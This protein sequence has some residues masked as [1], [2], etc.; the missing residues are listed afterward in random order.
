MHKILF[1][2]FLLSIPVSGF[3]QKETKKNV[4]SNTG[5][6]TKM[7][8]AKQKL[9]AGD[10]AGALNVYRDIEKTNPGNSTVKYY[11]GYCQFLLKQYDA[12]KASLLKAVELNSELKPET[13]VVLGQLYQ[14]EEKYDDAISQFDLFNALA[15]KSNVDEEMKDDAKLHLSQCQVAKKLIANPLKVTV[16]NL[17]AGLNS[18]YDDKN[19]CMTADGT[20]LVFT[21]RRPETTSSE[22]D[23]EGDGGYY[24]NIYTSSLDSLTK[25]FIKTESAGGTINS[26][27]H[28]ACTSIS[29]DGKQIFI[30]KNDA[31]KLE[32]RGGNVF[33]SKVAGDKWKTPATLGKPVNSKYWEG[34]A[35]VSPDGKTYFFSSE[36]PGGLG[37]SDIWMVQSVNRKTWGKPENL[38]PEVNTPYDEAGMF[39]APDGKTLF[40]C[41]NGPNSMGSYDIFK[42]VFENGKWSKAQNVGYPI[43][44]SAKEG[45]LTLSTDARKAY[46]S[47]DRQGGIGQSDLYKID[48]NGYAILEKEGAKKPGNGLSI[49][50]GTIREGFEGYGMADVEINL[51][52]QNKEAVA[53]SSTN[54]NGDYFFT[55]PG[56]S[57]EI[58]VKKKGYQTITEK[59]DLPIQKDETVVLEKG[60]LLKK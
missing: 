11:V 35:C 33:V 31:S 5:D 1:F 13:H 60:Y 43:N 56:G 22:I 15:L 47:S 19:P 34:G 17:G 57:Y 54:E 46:I 37:K 40:F 59:F 20:K 38:G 8:L 21:T 7:A 41:S 25:E 24:E 49:L 10:N 2:L 26:K 45:Q 3:S 12:S 53:N 51:L 44:S 9:Y 29:A 30:Y 6:A 52:N 58:E 4:F 50:K 16:T 18:K 14:L 42:T 36:R 39:L 28:D 32:S 23:I 27:T 55:L 48:L